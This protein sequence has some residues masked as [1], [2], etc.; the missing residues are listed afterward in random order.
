MSARIW[1]RR[2]GPEGWLMRLLTRPSAPTADLYIANAC[3]DWLADGKLTR[4]GPTAFTTDSTLLLLRHDARLAPGLR[5]KRLVYLIDDAWE[6]G[7]RDAS[8]SPFY[9]SKIALVERR[10]ARF[11][12]P[13]AAAVVVSS[14]ALLASAQALTGAKVHLLDPYWSEPL[15]DLAHFAHPG[16]DIAF[17]GAQLHA[18]DLRF[19]L[20]VLARTLD[21]HADVTVTLSAG[22]ALPSELA[23]HPRLRLMAGLSWPAYRAA[24]RDRRFHLALYP[25]RATPF[26]A[27]RSRNKIVE[28]A[29]VGAAPLYSA[30]WPPGD[31][32]AAAGAGLAL[33][34]RPEIWAAAIAALIADR[35]RMARMAAAARAHASR[36]NDPAAQRRL[37]AA[38]LDLGA[39]A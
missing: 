6:A 13:R 35:P 17:L 38:L 21:T 33:P 26:N 10:A 27:G 34:E 2:A 37:W 9:R 25:L 29:V 3:A 15:P 22:H 16:T 24:L 18:D 12:M 1:L 14:P 36:I 5:R 11:Y 23:A 19:L 39:A 30:G 31:A 28:H 8:L 20:P 7:P 4:P 32:A